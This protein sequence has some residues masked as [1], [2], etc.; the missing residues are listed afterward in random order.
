[1]NLGRNSVKKIFL[2]TWVGMA[3]SMLSICAVLL[4]MTGESW[5]LIC[6]GL[7]M[8]CALAWMFL[9]TVVFSKRLSIFTRELCQAM[10]QMISGE[11]ARAL[12]SET[13]FA[14]I[15]Y[16]LLRLYGIMQENRRR[17]RIYP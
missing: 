8:L 14:R 6:G 1:M 10:D 2:L 9:L 12:D 4:W 3:I 11:P 17:K 5:V 15:S 13:L 16:R 7:L